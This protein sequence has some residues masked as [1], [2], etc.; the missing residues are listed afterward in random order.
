[1]NESQI[2]AY[3]RAEGLDEDGVEDRLDVEADRKLQQFKDDQD[4]NLGADA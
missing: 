3:L 4:L 1:M 2:R